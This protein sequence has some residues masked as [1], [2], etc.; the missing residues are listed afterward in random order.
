MFPRK[1]DL[2]AGTAWSKEKVAQGES[3]KCMQISDEGKSK[4]EARLFSVVLN[5][6]R[7]QGEMGTN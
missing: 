1:K 5:G 2:R 3:H 4:I 6:M 7:E